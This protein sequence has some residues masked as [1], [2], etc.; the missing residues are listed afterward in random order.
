VTEPPFERPQPARDRDEEARHI[1][2][3]YERDPARILARIEDQLSILA[4]RAQ[5]LLSLAAVT[6]TVTGFSGTSIAKSGLP[7]AILLVTGLVCVILSAA[8]GIRGILTV[9]WTTS[10]APC[11]LESTLV[12]ALELRDRKTRAFG[13]SLRLLVIGLSLY[14]ASIA[15]LLVQVA[16]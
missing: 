3:L 6:I 13:T 14:V 1:L 10:F 7:A 4:A 16:R 8:L 12:G 5:T 9:R 2:A 15:F 11:S